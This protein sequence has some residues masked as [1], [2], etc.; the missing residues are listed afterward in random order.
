MTT[1][2]LL[3]FYQCKTQA[4]LAETIKVSLVTIWKWQKKG[5]PEKRQTYFEVLSKGRLKADLTCHN[6]LANA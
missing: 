4:E 6:K 2:D 1:D 5:I 3:N